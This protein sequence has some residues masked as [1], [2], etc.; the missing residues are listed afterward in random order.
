VIRAAQPPPPLE[1]EALMNQPSPH[2]RPVQPPS[3][4]DLLATRSASEDD[5]DFIGSSAPEHDSSVNELSS[6][7]IIGEPTPATPPS[8]T[9]SDDSTPVV[10]DG[11]FALIRKLGEG[12]MGAVYK[13]RQISFNRTVALK[14]LFP[15]VARNPKLV[16]RLYREARAMALLD[17]PN[18]IQAYA[19]GEEHGC[20]YVAM[21]YVRGDNLQKLL[22]KLGRLDV[23]DAVHIAIACARGLAYAHRQDMIHRDIKPDNILVTRDGRVKIAD[24]GMVKTFDDDLALTQTGHAV[25]TPWYMPLE[26]AKNSKDTD[27]RCDI[28]ALGCTLYCLLTGSPPFAGATIVD[29]I[30]AKEQ[31]TFPPVRTTNREVPERLD[32]VIAKMTAK[33]P[34]YRYPNCDELVADL[35]SLHLAGPTLKLLAAPADR[36]E[37]DVAGRSSGEII[38][39]KSIT[40]DQPD[41]NLWYVRFKGPGGQL[42]LKK[43]TTA[44]LQKKLQE[45]GI[46]PRCQASHSRQ[47]GFRSLAT[48]RELEAVA[49]TRA[50][51]TAVDKSAAHYRS[52][53]KKIEEQDRK[54]GEGEPRQ[55]TSL[56]EWVNFLV[57]LGA[58][59]LG[60]G[61]VIAFIWYVVTGLLN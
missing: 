51:K 42:L 39:P 14:V 47:D 17:H 27:Q 12:A 22:N 38:T 24:L 50:T 8:P 4:E 52:L 59:I 46:D 56:P 31:G 7:R 30:R 53:Y 28:Y 55:R 60:V 21:E 29:V 6:T 36:T 19:V 13:A 34:K 26:Q 54:R 32:L 40:G 25:G 10:V 49:A 58:L 16:E 61:L 20:P 35:E 43:Y 9:G 11:E 2:S 23:A 1:D 33:D 41:P 44:Q 18:I 3:S 5:T 45:G 48:Y 15:H 37:V 57:T